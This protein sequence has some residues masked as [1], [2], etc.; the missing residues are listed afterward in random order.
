MGLNLDPGQPTLFP[1]VPV[2][3]CR[4]IPS[5]SYLEACG[6]HISALPRIASCHLS[7]RRMR[8]TRDTYN[9]TRT[10]KGRQ[11]DFSSAAKPSRDY[12]LGGLSYFSA[13]GVVGSLAGSISS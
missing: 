10:S 8:Y 13:R 4:V 7:Y 11:R 9:Q 1:R 6:G 3:G 5:G 12:G 2:P